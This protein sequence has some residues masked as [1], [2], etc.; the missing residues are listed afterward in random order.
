MKNEDNPYSFESTPLRLTL[1]GKKAAAAL[2]LLGAGIGISSCS[3]ETSGAIG[4]CTGAE[5]YTVQS[6]DTLTGVIKDEVHPTGDLGTDGGITAITRAIQVGSLVIGRTYVFPS[7]A[8]TN[9]TTGATV[10][11]P[12]IQ[13]GETITIPEKC[14][15]LP[16]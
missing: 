4:V 12:A 11:V 1:R 3:S 9:Y 2:A 8:Y 16:R 15:A 10:G 7:D 5:S 14:E 6:G 13:T